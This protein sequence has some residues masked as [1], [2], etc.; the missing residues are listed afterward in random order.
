M[1]LEPVPNGKGVPQVSASTPEAGEPLPANYREDE[2]LLAGRAAVFAGPVTGPVKVESTGHKFVTRVLV[3]AP[4][5]AADFSG[6]VWVE[7]LNTSG[8]PEADVIWS[9]LAPL[10][11]SRGDAW[12]GVTVR[13]NQVG[14]LQKFD[15]VRYADLDLSQ[16]AYEWDVL[17]EVGALVKTNNPES[18]LADLDV[19]HAYLG[20]YSQSGVDTATFATAFNATTRLADGAAVYDGYLIGA[21]ESNLSPL[22]SGDTIIPQFE[23]APLPPIDVPV[24]DVE[25]Q[26]DV[27]GF[28]VEV[29]TALAKQEGLAG[30]DDDRHPD[31][32]VRERRWSQGAARRQ[33]HRARIAIGSTRYRERRTR[34][35]VTAATASRRSRRGRSPERRRRTWRVGRRTV[36]RRR[37]RRAST[38]ANAGRRLGHRERR[39]RQRA[40]RDPVAVRRRPAVP[41][42]GAHRPRA[43]LHP[44][45]ERDVVGRRRP[46]SPLRRRRRG[47]MDAFTA[48]LDKTI[49][50]G[51]LLELDRKALLD[52]QATR[53]Q[54]AFAAG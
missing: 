21:R 16:N 31:V 48:S 5:D 45:R 41:L 25:P 53:A 52:T 18:P 35:T 42:R 4:R 51:F 30:A 32:H 11:A 44:E 39:A 24:M 3:R 19:Q 7:P 46:H 15:A 2:H 17:R 29:P 34:G 12:I 43:L 37:R 22:Q 33:R 23:R 9:A 6:S 20:G 54:A 8:G 14:R 40:R 28:A 26:T 36:S 27:E 50:A 10:I 38:L 49:K 13:A 1:Q 47:Y